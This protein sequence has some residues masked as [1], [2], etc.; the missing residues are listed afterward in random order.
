MPSIVL[1]ANIPAPASEVWKVVGDF[2]GLTKFSP[3]I[4]QSTVEGEGV[5][6]LR[7]LQLAEG[8][9]IV[10][11]LESYDADERTLSYSIVESPL[12]LKDYLSTMRVATTDEGCH[13]EWGGTCEADGA[14][15]HEVEQLLLGIYSGGLTSLGELFVR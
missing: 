1:N 6:A 13:V 5:G 12:P 8:G 11:R 4:A 3:A 2:N 14:T 10:E 15:D 9:T 7:T